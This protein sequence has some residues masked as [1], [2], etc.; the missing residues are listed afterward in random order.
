MT[1]NFKK[2]LTKVRENAVKVQ[3][4]F[5]VPMCLPKASWERANDMLKGDMMIF[6][7]SGDVSRFCSSRTPSF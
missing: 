1:V 2:M 4:A 3:S 7:R 5:K 6:G